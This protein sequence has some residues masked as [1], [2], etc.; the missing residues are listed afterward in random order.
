MS[1]QVYLRVSVVERLVDGGSILRSE[2]RR[3]GKATL[4]AT[5]GLLAYPL[6]YGPIDSNEA[7]RPWWG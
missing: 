6:M 7:L 4:S 5:P 2:V 1:R 3:Y